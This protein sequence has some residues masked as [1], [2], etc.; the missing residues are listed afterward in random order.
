MRQ[1]MRRLENG[2]PPCYEASS[3]TRNE[4]RH[5]VFRLLT[6]LLDCT[7]DAQWRQERDSQIVDC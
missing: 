2:T 6:L 4:A 3:N 1:M 5:T 7:H